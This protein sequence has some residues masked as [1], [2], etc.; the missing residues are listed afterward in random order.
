MNRRQVMQSLLGASVLAPIG[1]AAAGDDPAGVS[2]GKLR[3]KWLYFVAD[4]FV[5]DVWKNGDVVP[6][7]KR[8]LLHEIYGATV[9]R[10]NLELSAGDWLVF[11]AVNNRLRWNGCRF[12]GMAAMAAESETT[13]FAPRSRALQQ[14]GGQRSG[15]FVVLL[16]NN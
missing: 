6:L 15:R 16:R 12:F 14:R 9:E 2:A 13:I 4:D 1:S 11:H 3:A 10:V 7:S 8:T 5:V